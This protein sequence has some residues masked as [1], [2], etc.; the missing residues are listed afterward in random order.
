[1]IRAVL[2]DLGNVVIDI[3][4]ER[5]FDV[6]AEAA[7]VDRQHFRERWQMDAAYREH[8]VGDRNFE[9]YV[10][11]L[12]QRFEV[13][14]P[15][16]VWRSGWNSLFTGAYPGVIERLP[17]VARQVPLYCFSNTNAEHHA[18]WGS[19][20]RDDLAAFS[21]IFVSSSIGLRKPDVAA[22]EH[23][24]REMDCE[25]PEVLFLDDTPGNIK[26]AEQ[27]GTPCVNVSRPRDVER[28]LDRVLDST[29]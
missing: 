20:Y 5:V 12:E 27:P 28:A 6:W 13:A 9:G 14:L 26:G 10:E 22:Y 2:L 16:E 1:M 7:D 24:L 11:A 25:G 23:V 17:A 18:Y 21:R 29:A 4:F 15:L 8:E 3:D 19:R